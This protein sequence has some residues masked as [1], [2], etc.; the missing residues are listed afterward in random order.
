MP[1]HGSL[2]R[3]VLPGLARLIA[4]A[5]AL[6]AMTAEAQEARQGLRQRARQLFEALPQDMA[7]KE[8]PTTPARVALG[9][10]MFFD[11]R[12]SVDGTV[13]C[14]TCHRPGL[15]GTDA[16]A[17]SIGAEHRLNARNAPTV[18]N[19]AL[20]FKQ[21]WIGDRANVEEQAMKSLVGH[22]SFGN[23]DYGVVI[24]KIK[25]LGY[26]GEFA[27]TFPDDRDPVK[28]ENWGK[29][30]GAYERTLATPSPFDAYLNGDLKALSSQAQRGLETFI[31]IGCVS[32]HN[33]VAVGGSA[34]QKFGIFED[35]GK[36]T[37]S[38]SIDEGRFNETKAPADKYVFKAPSLRNVAMTPPYFHDGSVATLPQAVH[39]MGKVQLGKEL[40]DRE[41]SDLVSLLNSL[42]GDLPKDFATEPVLT[43]RAFSAPT[44]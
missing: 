23:P 15:Y 3:N 32:C 30:I 7:T 29:A 37:R 4:V 14:S 20:Q 17:K 6:L 41:V 36:E 8:F 28:P 5:A 31:N 9:R 42:T 10:K 40:T 12:L 18:L 1:A 35:Y 26:A 24:R 22:A 16:L 39:V 43:S 11:P 13:S 44:P 38:Q 2:A 25:T 19:A 33:G 27:Q 34:F 21:H